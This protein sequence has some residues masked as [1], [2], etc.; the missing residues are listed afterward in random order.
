M[1]S[2]GSGGPLKAYIKENL[3]KI[4][5]LDVGLMQSDMEISHKTFLVPLFLGVIMVP[6]PSSVLVSSY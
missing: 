2:S 4:L 3:F 6:L 1:F 5:F